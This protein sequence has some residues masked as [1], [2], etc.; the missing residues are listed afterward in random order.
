M[1]G[2]RPSYSPGKKVI[3]EPINEHEG[4]TMLQLDVLSFFVVILFLGAIFLP[5]LWNGA[6]DPLGMKKI[7]F[8]T[9][10]LFIATWFCFVTAAL[11]LLESM[12]NMLSPGL[13]EKERLF[14]TPFQNVSPP[15][16][17]WAA[18]LTL[19]WWRFPVRT[20]G[21][22][23]FSIAGAIAACVALMIALILIESLGRA[24]F[25]ERWRSRWTFLFL[26]AFFLADA[27]TFASVALVR[28]I[29]WLW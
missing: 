12:R 26:A 23:Q 3:A 19:G 10:A 11:V 22:A 2:S 5:L 13:W 28:Q 15:S 24:F 18:D 21:E 8:R 25:K 27:V 17:S 29:C 9:G 16:N 4:L 1:A 14:S 7:G 6:F 20:F